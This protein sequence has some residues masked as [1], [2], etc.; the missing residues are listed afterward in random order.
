MSER[1]LIIDDDLDMCLLLQRFLSKH[2]Y[3]TTVQYKGQRGIAAYQQEAFDAVICDYRL[4]DMDAMRVLEALQT[5]DPEVKFIV[6]TG[7]SNT[8]TA[9][10]IMKLGACDY[11]SKPLV[12]EDLLKVVRQSIDNK[13]VQAETKPGQPRLGAAGKTVSSS[14]KLYTESRSEA[15]RKVFSLIGIVAPTDYNVILYGESG[16]GKEVAARMIHE[17]SLRRNRPF[18]AIDCGILSRELAASE[19]FGHVKGSFTGAQQDREGHFAT[20]HGG[21]LFLD[22]VANLPAEVQTTL[23][24]VIQERR[25][26]PVG[27]N[28]EMVADV[29]I[30]VASNESLAEA[31]RSGKFR[32]DIYHRFNEFMIQLPALRNRSEDIIPLAELFL[33]QACE[34][35]G[36]VT[37]G[38]EKA[39]MERLQTYAWPGNLR[40]LRNVVRRCV[41]LTGN[42]QCIT[43]E[44]F[45]HELL[46]PAAVQQHIEELPSTENDLLTNDTDM[47]TDMEPTM[48]N[49]EDVISQFYRLK[50]AASKAE[51]NAILQ[52]LKLANFNKKKAAAILK[53]DRKTLYNKLKNFRLRFTL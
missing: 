22:E 44:C 52:A 50:G 38:F 48:E 13:P 20:A 11:I 7:Y 8:R 51:Y 23:L 32:E 12:P 2:G 46:A 30:I 21:T 3:A 19:L 29:R 16:T 27:S 36:R 25:F 17:Q 53:I 47:G 18:V 35:T 33:T 6:I 34:E 5:H 10:E 37:T 43:M 4:G 26:R 28:K 45:P 41:L 9:V 39:V 1:I 31:Y 49:V 15:M 40:E 24:R 14:P 42:D